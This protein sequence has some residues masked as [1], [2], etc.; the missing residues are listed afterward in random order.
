MEAAHIDQVVQGAAVQPRLTLTVPRE[1]IVSELM[2]R[3]GATVMPGMPLARIQGTGTVWAEGQLPETQAAL[4][5]PGM[6]ASL[7]SPALPGRRFEGRVQALLPEVDT[8]TRTIR[9]RMETA[10]PG[11]ALVP[12]MLVQM[13][14]APAPKRVLL[15]PS[16]AVIHTGRRSVVMLAEEGGHFRPVEVRTGTESGDRTEIVSGLAAGQR[17]VLSAQFLIDSEASLRG[18]EARLKQ[19]AAPAYKTEAVVDA[20]EGDTLTLT[21]PPIPALKWPQMTMEFKRSAATSGPS[22]LKKGE[23]IEIEFRQQEGEVPLV[24]RIE[25]LPAAGRPAA[26]AGGKR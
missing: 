10:N 22:T 18:L 11:R 23:R 5:R 6:G 4:L 8:A 19:G 25:R 21:H 26:S 24:T 13:S 2:A 7:T 16:D 15:V 17:V 12:G 3:E 20:V 9:V 1:G 14:F